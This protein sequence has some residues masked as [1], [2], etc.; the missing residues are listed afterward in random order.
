M[1][2]ACEGACE[3]DPVKPIEKAM[4][5]VRMKFMMCSLVRWWA[6]LDR[7]NTSVYELS[8]QLI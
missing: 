6:L 5:V 3:G 7:Y 1:K 4:R 8:C 2:G